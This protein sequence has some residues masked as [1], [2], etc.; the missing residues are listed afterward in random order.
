MNRFAFIQGLPVLL[1]LGLSL[2][3]ARGDGGVIRLRELQGPF[4]VTIFTAAES[5]QDTP[6]DVSV[7]VQGRDSSD[8]ILDA[9]VILVFT[10]PAASIAEPIEQI[11]G[12]SEMAD[13]GTHSEQFTV[14]ATRRQASNKL[15][16]AAP[17]KFGAAGNWQLRAFIRREG[18]AVEIACSLPVSSPPRKLM[19]LF[20][21]LILPP[22]M[23]ALFALNQCLRRQSL[24]KMRVPSFT[25]LL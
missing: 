16:Y 18:D 19:A 9:K 23:V 3:N 24:E 7:M 5:L 10:P 22:L 12:V 20:P 4:V 11:C 13:L 14:A 15:L 2:V 8:A 6:V 17:V 25:S 21:C 1:L